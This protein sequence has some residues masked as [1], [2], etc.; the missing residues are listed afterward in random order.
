MK[1]EYKLLNADGVVETI[2]GGSNIY[3]AKKN[4]KDGPFIT[5]ERIYEKEP[6]A[7]GTVDFET[8]RITLEYDPDTRND[9]ENN[10]KIT[11]T[12]GG[13]EEKEEE[14]TPS[15]IC[16]GRFGTLFGVGG[17]SD[18]LFI[19]GSDDF[20]NADFYSAS[21]DFTYFAAGQ[22]AVLGADSS[23]IGGYVRLS[24][25]TL[26]ILKENPINEPAIYYRTGKSGSDGTVF[27]LEAGGGGESVITPYACANF[28]G[29]PILLSA[30]GVF[31]IE[32]GGNV[33]T[34]ERYSRHR[35]LLINKK[36]NAYNAADLRGAV[37]VVF[38]DRYY[39]SIGGACFIADARYKYNDSQA[40]SS[41]NYE[42]WYWENV[43]ARV[44]LAM[45]DM[46]YFGTSD[47]RVCVF[48]GEYTDRSY[49]TVDKGEIGFNISN[50]RI[51]FAERI[52]A[53]F[54]DG[55]GITFGGGDV[56]ALYYDTQNGYIKDNAI[57]TGEDDITDI[58]EGAEV[59]CDNVGESGLES[60][61]KYTIAYVDL[62]E[63][64]FK[65]NKDGEA[66]EIKSGGFKLCRYVTGQELTVCEKDATTFRVKSISAKRP[67]DIV[68]Y[69]SVPP[70][71]IRADIERRQIVFA[72]WH[73]GVFDLG[74][75][76][77]AKTLLGM[78][79]AADPQYNGNLKLGVVGKR[80][81]EDFTLGGTRA[82]AFDEVDFYDFS[83]DTDFATSY[84]V[85][86]NLRN[87]NYVSLHF[88]SEDDKA[89][90]MHEMSLLYKIN[91][92]NRG[93]V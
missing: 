86:L 50:G 18:R 80:S 60:N 11:Y 88:K 65:L 2:Y 59:Y 58:Y 40:L 68:A 26:A 69:G 57:Y 10:V 33:A 23:A 1:N 49:Y 92:N 54:A 37:G 44:W 52:G 66:V 16:C 61:V 28:Y 31:G 91:K 46:L 22:S 48:D 75:N 67:L 7:V 32:L 72:E 29:D 83:F 21:D 70:S 39:L 71:N 90:S 85:R 84:S 55:D 56:Y 81:A 14:L 87:V 45:D 51:T 74:T 13:L 77:A 3:V 17:N 20:K 27:P 8:G 76:T 79:V 35:S 19:A 93:V 47:G 78:T 5:Y 41:F 12:I 15:A 24:D 82:F 9:K 30:N 25:S 4:E 6:Y 38:K 53:S 34:T 63:C 36:L 42:W 73:S 89:C 43:P 62:G 64:F